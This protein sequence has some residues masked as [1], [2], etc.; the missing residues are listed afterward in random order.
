MD[1]P[2]AVRIVLADNREQD[3]DNSGTDSELLAD[4]HT[5]TM[6]DVHGAS[7]PGDDPQ[8][9]DAYAVFLAATWAAISAVM[10]LCEFDAHWASGAHAFGAASDGVAPVVTAYGTFPLCAGCRSAGHMTDA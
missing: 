10:C 2:T 5:I 8:I 6:D 1:L 4:A 9:V 3:P 7:N